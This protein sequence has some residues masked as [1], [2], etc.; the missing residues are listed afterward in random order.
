MDSV[1]HSL[2]GFWKA[3]PTRMRM[4]SY[5]A[6]KFM[7]FINLNQPNFDIDAN[8]EIILILK[9]IFRSFPIDGAML[10]F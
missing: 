6:S 3:E 1:T 4:L 7:K 10:Y 9:C 2:E 5:F 8:R